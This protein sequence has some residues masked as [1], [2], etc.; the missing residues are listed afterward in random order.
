MGIWGRKYLTFPV[1]SWPEL[2]RWV[3]HHVVVDGL[4][5]DGVGTA[6]HKDPPVR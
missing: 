1:A 6:N 2:I 4:V 3:V 5:A